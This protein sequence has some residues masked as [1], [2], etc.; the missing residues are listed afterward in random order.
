[1]PPENPFESPTADQTPSQPA[2]GGKQ[3]AISFVL[4]TLFLDILG[5]GIVIPVLPKLVKSFIAPEL[6][7]SASQLEEIE[8][9]K[10]D[11]LS[12]GLKE[13]KENLDSDAS[14][15]IGII[16]CTYALTQ[17]LFAPIVGALSDRFGRRP[18]ILGSLFGFAIDFL[19][20]GFANS[21]MWLF[22]GRF[23]AGIMGASFSTA[24]AYVADVSTPEN[25]ARNFGLVGMMFGLGFICGPALG[26]L[27]GSVHER[28]PFFVAAGLAFANWVYGFLVLPESLPPEQRS[29]I[30]IGKLNPFGTLGRLLDYPLIAGLAI[31]F[32]F[33]S[34]AQRGLENVWVIYAEHRFNWNPLTNGMV[35]GLVGVMAVIVQGGM[36]RPTIK[37]LGERKTVLAGICV[38]LIAF[39]GYG[40][41]WIPWMIPCLI[42]FGAFGGVAGPAIQSIVAGQVEPSEQG[43][44]QGALT[45]LTSLTNIL[46]PVFFNTILFSYFTSEAAP[47]RLPGAPFLAGAVCWAIALWFAVAVF[48]KHLEKLE[49]SSAEAK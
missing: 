34:F 38:S 49:P 32:L 48:K 25:R 9:K 3:A 4:L 30:S 43:K 40:I 36:V 33:M 11:D 8:S 39:I 46:A 12:G 37:R 15:Y 7:I 13:L 41:A 6:S 1:M 18:I 44:I 45:S 42:V 35:L 14:W 5:I 27:L 31:P 23:L 19:I 10:V 22:V 16:S 47:I 17:F 26:G 24:N 2:R 20:Q 29:S 28:L 21:V